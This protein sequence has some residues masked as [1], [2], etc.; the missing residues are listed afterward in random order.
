M[1]FLAQ[2]IVKEADTVQELREGLSVLIPKTCD[3]T[4]Y[5][6]A[7]VLG[8]GVATVV[9]HAQENSRLSCREADEGKTLLR[10]RNQSF[11]SHG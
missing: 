11:F 9:S 4:Y 6:T 1:V 8:V 5:E 7:K 2:Q 3:I 10:K